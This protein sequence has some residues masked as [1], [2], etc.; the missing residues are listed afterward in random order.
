[1]RIGQ[2]IAEKTPVF[3]VEFFPP[4]TDE[5]RTQLFDTART[6]RAIE[7]AYARMW[8]AWLA[9]KTPEGFAVPDA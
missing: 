1:M 2:K 4:K 7:A 6:C 9:G 3:S 8:Q 5:G